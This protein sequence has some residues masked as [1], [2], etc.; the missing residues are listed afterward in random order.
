MKAA[1]TGVFCNMPST[2]Q[3]GH[4]KLTHQHP[5]IKDTTLLLP[6]QGYDRRDSSP[7]TLSVMAS[8]QGAGETDTLFLTF[9]QSLG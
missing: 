7:A 8:L 2:A 3:S 5:K 4:L 9:Q 6:W 1:V